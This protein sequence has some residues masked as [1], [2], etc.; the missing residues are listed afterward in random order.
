MRTATSRPSG[1]NWRATP[2]TLS[3]ACE[4]H[5]DHGTG[6]CVGS[7]RMRT[8]IL[9]LLSACA[10]CGCSKKEASSAASSQ[11]PTP[12]QAAQIEAQ[13]VLPTPEPVATPA[14]PATPQ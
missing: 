4:H 14:N 3:P 9:L 8:F 12:E 13:Y 5:R 10:I 11:P 7:M 1:H 2:N 6:P